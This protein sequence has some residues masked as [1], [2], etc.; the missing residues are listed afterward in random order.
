MTKTT[1]TQSARPPFGPLVSSSDDETEFQHGTVKSRCP[2][3]DGARVHDPPDTK[4]PII[5]KFWATRAAPTGL[6]KQVSL[7]VPASPEVCPL[8]SLRPLRFVLTV[9]AP[10]RFA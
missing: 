3:P 1:S 6:K 8:K 7:A 4:E 9:P 2:I 10:L 5:S